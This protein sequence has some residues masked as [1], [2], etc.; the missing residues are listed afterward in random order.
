MNRMIDESFFVEQQN[1]EVDKNDLKKLKNECK[2]CVWV[3]IDT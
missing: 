1:Y 3:L 2:L